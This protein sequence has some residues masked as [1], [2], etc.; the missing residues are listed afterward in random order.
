[1]HAARL[2]I[3][4]SQHDFSLG[5]IASTH[6][7]KTSHSRLLRTNSLFGWRKLER[8]EVRERKG[9]I[10]SHLDRKLTFN[11]LWGKIPGLVIMFL[12]LLKTH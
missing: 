5:H 6:I 1:M 9:F 11:K 4:N 12:L 8:K 2:L 3:A 10:L 7:K